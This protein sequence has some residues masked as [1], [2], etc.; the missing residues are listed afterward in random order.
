MRADTYIATGQKAQATNVCFLFSVSKRGQRNSH[1]G[2]GDRRPIP[3]MVP[4]NLSCCFSPNQTAPPFDERWEEE[5]VRC[6]VEPL[7][8]KVYHVGGVS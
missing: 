7:Y 3:S 8:P 6:A 1:T 5:G 2:P 4:W